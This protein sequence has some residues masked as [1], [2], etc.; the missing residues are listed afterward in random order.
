[1]TNSLMKDGIFIWDLEY[2]VVFILAKYYFSVITEFQ[3]VAACVREI[4][5]I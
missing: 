5:F 2:Q 3:L 1:M 4:I